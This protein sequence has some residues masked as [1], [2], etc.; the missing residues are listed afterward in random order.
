MSVPV[1]SAWDSMQSKLDL[2]L[3]SNSCALMQSF[4]VESIAHHVKS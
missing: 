4:I 2:K 3:F 1:K